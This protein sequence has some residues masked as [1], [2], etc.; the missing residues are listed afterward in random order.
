M[1]VA[2]CGAAIAAKHR[3]LVPLLS[4]AIGKLGHRKNAWRPLRPRD[5][6]YPLTAVPA[7]R[8]LSLLWISLSLSE[9][10]DHWKSNEERQKQTLKWQTVLL[11]IVAFATQWSPWSQVLI[12]DALQGFSCS[13]TKAVFPF[14]VS[15]QNI[16]RVSWSWGL[17]D[18]S[19]FPSHRT[20][21]K[22][23]L[24]TLCCSA[25]NLNVH[26]SALLTSIILSL[27]SS[28]FKHSHVFASRSG[29]SGKC[30]LCVC[31]CLEKYCTALGS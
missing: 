6:S 21:K 2:F 1:S 27:W 31:V 18:V 14:S 8:T 4:Q 13:E 30:I 25:M 9:C 24:S 15:D 5:R 20:L 16:L 12:K 23:Y 3:T 17:T 7:P 29:M 10:K 11:A 28:S 22:Q 19:N 26:C